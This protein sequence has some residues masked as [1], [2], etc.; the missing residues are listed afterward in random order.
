MSDTSPHY[1]LAKRQEELLR[2]I[3]D[4]ITTS[5]LM[6]IAWLWFTM[7]VTY[8]F[9]PTMMFSLEVY[10]RSHIYVAAE[11]VIC[12]SMDAFPI[13]PFILLR[14]IRIH[15]DISIGLDPRFSRWLD[16]AQ[17]TILRLAK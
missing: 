10:C 6:P 7:H 13:V 11:K 14:E 1:D 5:G 12:T 2:C 15:A 4:D 16:Q 8:Q 9:T 3:S 17:P